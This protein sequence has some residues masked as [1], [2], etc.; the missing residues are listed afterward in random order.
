MMPASELA[1]GS[2]RRLGGCGDAGA[3]TLGPDQVPAPLG[4]SARD[5]YGPLARPWIRSCER[6]RAEGD[7]RATKSLAPLVE[8]SAPPPTGIWREQLNAGLSS[9]SIIRWVP[10]LPADGLRL[11]R[12]PMVTSPLVGRHAVEHR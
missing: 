9:H 4:A 5:G 7:Q 10:S 12:S 6:L 2:P 8:V 3:A 11:R 1:C